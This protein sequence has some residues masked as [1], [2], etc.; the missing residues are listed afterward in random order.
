MNVSELI[1][2]YVAD[3]AVQLVALWMWPGPRRCIVTL[4]TLNE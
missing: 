1:E 2:A 4:V 3:V